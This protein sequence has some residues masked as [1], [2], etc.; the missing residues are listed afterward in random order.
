[1]KGVVVSI[2]LVVVLVIK[3]VFRVISL[4]DDDDENVVVEFSS[5][6]SS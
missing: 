5:S 2:S 1:V 4:D 6:S 3:A